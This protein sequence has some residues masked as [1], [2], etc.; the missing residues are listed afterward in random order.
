MALAGHVSHKMME[1]Y[2]HIRNEAKR[3]AVDA[4]SGSEFDEGWAQNRAQFF[5]SK[6][7][8][9]VKSLKKIW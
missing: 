7:S 1:R 5:E 6:K 4:L 2:S 3:I 8:E 9:E